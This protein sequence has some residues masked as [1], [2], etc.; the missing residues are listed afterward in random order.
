MRETQNLGPGVCLPG[1]QPWFVPCGAVGLPS[2]PIPTIVSSALRICPPRA[3]KLV[4][5]PLL[6]LEGR[7]SSCTQTTPGQHAGS[8]VTLGTGL[9]RTL[10][11]S[12]TI[13]L[14]QRPRG[15]AKW[16]KGTRYESCILASVHERQPWSRPPFLSCP[17]HSGPSPSLCWD[18]RPCPTPE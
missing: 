7:G 10:T 13:G 12:A 5:F 16:R 6:P 14:T 15:G 8:K 18:R 2:D 9:K 11:S 1:D 3:S 4:P 17:Y